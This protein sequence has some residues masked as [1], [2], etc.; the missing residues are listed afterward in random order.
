MGSRPMIPATN[1]FPRVLQCF[2]NLGRVLPYE[3]RCTA[4]QTYT[5]WV[6]SVFP[7]P[8]G[9]EA[10]KILQYK[11]WRCTGMF[12]SKRWC[13]CFRHSSEDTVFQWMCPESWCSKGRNVAQ[14][15]DACISIYA[16]IYI[17]TCTYVWRP[18][19]LWSTNWRF[20][21]WPPLRIEGLS[22]PSPDFS[23]H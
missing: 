17:Y 11:T 1:T 22:S 12:S 16:Y 18:S 20:L 19:P 7:F 14:T 9:P 10:L 2:G 13:W 3:W 21:D 4:T 8:Q 15:L 5:Q 23:R 6:Y